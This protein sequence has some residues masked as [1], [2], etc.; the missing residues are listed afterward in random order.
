MASNGKREPKSVSISALTGEGFDRLLK[1]IGEA[2]SESSVEAEL[3]LAPEDGADLA[4]AYANGD[5]LKRTNDARGRVKLK[6]A[7]VADALPKFERRF[8]ARLVKSLPDR[9]A[10]QT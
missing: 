6:V 9:G 7:I 3:R 8:G 2:L 1:M 10:A 5:V 4:W